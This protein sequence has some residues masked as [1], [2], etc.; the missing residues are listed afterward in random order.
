MRDLSDGI[1]QQARACP[2][3]E[4]AC[5][6]VSDFL[7]SFAR[8][9]AVSMST[10]LSWAMICASLSRARIV[11]F[12]CYEALPCRVF[13]VLENALVARVVGDDEEEGWMGFDGLPSFVD[14]QHAAVISEAGE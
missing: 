4:A 1:D 2:F 10:P 9:I 12:D 6:E 8:S 14:R 3:L 11:E 13:Q 7:P 5:F